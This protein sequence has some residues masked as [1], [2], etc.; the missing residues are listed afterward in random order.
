MNCVKDRTFSEILRKKH[1]VK[2]YGNMCNVNWH[3][4]GLLFWRRNFN[5][6]IRFSSLERDYSLS[7][8]IWLL[9]RVWDRNTAKIF[10]CMIHSDLP[11]EKLKL[12]LGRYSTKQLVRTEIKISQRKISWFFYLCLLWSIRVLLLV[13]Y[14]LVLRYEA[15][16]NAL[17]P[18]SYVAFLPCRMQ[19]RQ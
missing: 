8:E 15:R 2:V 4:I 5:I 18:G 9:K 17:R 16:V 11:R 12:T 10:S 14:D 1:N 13:K 3:L 19:L 7:K 6:M